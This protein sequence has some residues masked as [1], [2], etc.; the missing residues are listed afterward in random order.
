MSFPVGLPLSFTVMMHTKTSDMIP[1]NSNGTAQTS[2]TIDPS[3]LISEKIRTGVPS[4]T[5]AVADEAA[6]AC[7]IEATTAA[8]RQTCAMA[9]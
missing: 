9:R 6:V 7:S 1:V 4:S 2:S 3:V 5:T 8:T